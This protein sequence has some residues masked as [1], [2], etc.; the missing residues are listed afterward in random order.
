[1]VLDTIIDKW[2]STQDQKVTWAISLAFLIIFPIYFANMAAFLPDGSVIGADIAGEWEVSFEETDE[3]RGEFSDM[4]GDGDIEEFDFSYTDTSKNLA[5]LEIVTSH[6]ETN[7]GGP[8][9]APSPW[10]NQCDTVSIDVMLSGISGFEEGETVSSST[11]DCGEQVLTILLIDGYNGTTYET[12]GKRSDVLA[13][14]SDNGS[15]RGD[16]Q[17]EI[18]L[19]V[20]TGGPPGPT[21]NRDN[22]EEVT[23]T[24][25]LVSAEVKLKAVVDTG[26]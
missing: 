7:E 5:Y 1:M 22:G 25:R 9:P 2:F 4:M 23:V 20:N 13:A 12:E 21:G 15:G 16:W 6:Q 24:W 18:T 19:D 17:F 8:G 3:V 14:N 10:Q 26:L 11:S